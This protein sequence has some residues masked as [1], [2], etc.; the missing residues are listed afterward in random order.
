MCA[1]ESDSKDKLLMSSVR[2]RKLP[3]HRLIDE[4]NH[5][6][7]ELEHEKRLTDI[8]KMSSHFDS[9]DSD[10]S[11]SQ[12]LTRQH[13]FSGNLL[14]SVTGSSSPSS[15]PS[16]SRNPSPALSLPNARSKRMCTL[17]SSN[18]KEKLINRSYSSETKPKRF[19]SPISDSDT[20][21]SVLSSQ[22][23][24]FYKC[25]SYN[26]SKSDVFP[27]SDDTKSSSKEVNIPNLDSFITVKSSIKKSEEISQNK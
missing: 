14:I 11:D 6:A 22:N 7:H 23:N 19:S 4:E 26:P 24:P 16:L 3:Q 12:Q 17:A 8:S 10:C 20:H 21:K 25:F 27:L 18:N 5:I 15:S 13:S 1:K 2:K 9:W